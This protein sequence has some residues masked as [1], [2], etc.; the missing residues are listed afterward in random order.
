[1][2]LMPKRVKHRK[3]QRG[4]LAG[5]AGSRNKLDFGDFGLQVLDRGWITN[6]QIEAARISVMRHLKRR[7]KLWFRIFPDKPYSKKPLETRMGKGKGNLEGW[8]APVL[9]GTVI[10][11]VSGCTE[12]TAKEAFARAAGKFSLP[13][14]FLSRS[15]A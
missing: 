15:N 6:H 1:M 4:S 10:M 2:P 8:V 5:I 9:P 7:G 14:K 13:C 3:V 11:E 12:T